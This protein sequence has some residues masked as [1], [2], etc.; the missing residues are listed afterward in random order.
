MIFY[1]FKEQIFTVFLSMAHLTAMTFPS[2]IYDYVGGQKG[3][4]QVY[5]LN[6]KQSLVFDPKRKDV[7]RNFI[8]FSQKGK[9]HFNIKYKEED[10]DKDVDIRLAQKCSLYSSIKDTRKFQLFECPRSLLVVNKSKTKIKVNEFY[11]EKK[12]YISKGPPVWING[13]LVYSKGKVL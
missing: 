1:V 3:D 2:K 8:V 5:E 9:F 4:F 10:A 13:D 11:V 12:K 7:D 6:K